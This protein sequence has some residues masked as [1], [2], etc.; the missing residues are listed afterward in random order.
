MKRL[1]AAL[2]VTAGLAIPSSASA[3][4]VAAFNGC[5]Y[6]GATYMDVV[7]QWW[8][9]G[10]PSCGPGYVLSVSTTTTVSATVTPTPTP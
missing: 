5:V 2:A 3:D 9:A 1:I 6:R 4:T 8:D 7:Q 10:S